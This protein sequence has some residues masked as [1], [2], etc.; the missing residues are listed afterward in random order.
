LE[1]SS[2]ERSL[3]GS[4]SKRS[5]PERRSLAESSPERRSLAESSPERWSL[6]EARRRE[7]LSHAHV[8]V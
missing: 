4:S 6:A 5:L 1:S 7:E 3:A 8:C 2:P